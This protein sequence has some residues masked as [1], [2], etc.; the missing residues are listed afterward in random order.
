MNSQHLSLMRRAELLAE[1]VRNQ[2]ADG[3]PVRFGNALDTSNDVY[4][5]RGF[6]WFSAWPQGVRWTCKYRFAIHVRLG[7]ECVYLVG[8]HWISLR[9]P[10][11]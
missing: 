11:E 5:N 9:I 2:S 4:R 8:G 1:N 6:K 10:Q 3:Q 7:K